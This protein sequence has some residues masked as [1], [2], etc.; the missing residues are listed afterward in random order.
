MT[1]LLELVA[2]G[3]T[4]EE[5]LA[6]YEFLEEEDMAAAILYAARS[7]DHPVILPEPAERSSPPGSATLF[8]SCA[9]AQG[10]P[11]PSVR[12]LA[13]RYHPSIVPDPFVQFA[14]IR[15]ILR[16]PYQ[17]VPHRIRSD[18]FPLRG[19]GIAGPQLAVPTVPLPK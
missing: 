2:A 18:V 10:P 16:V 15:P 7:A 1:D 19:V 4:R 8:H 17:P 11:C 12:P 5:I 6:E 9:F 13:G 14:L 3:A